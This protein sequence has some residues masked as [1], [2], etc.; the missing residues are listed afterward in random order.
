MSLQ[1][2]SPFD[3]VTGSV[4][5]S[6]RLFESKWREITSDHKI[7]DTVLHSHIE[8]VDGF[9][10]LQVSQVRPICMSVREQS[11]IDEGISKLPLKGV[12]VHSKPSFD[13]FCSS[14]AGIEFGKLHY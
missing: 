9:A 12:L 5:G 7:L 3:L 13:Q 6:L 14:C 11:V 2:S 4:A 1:V 10:P 8:F